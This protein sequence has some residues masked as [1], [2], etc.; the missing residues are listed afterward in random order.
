MSILKKWVGKEEKYIE[1]GKK[2]MNLW[3]QRIVNIPAMFLIVILPGLCGSMNH[4]NADT[5]WKPEYVSNQLII[6][7]KSDSPAAQTLFMSDENDDQTLVANSLDILKN[8]YKI[9]KNKTGFP[10][11]EK[12]R[13]SGT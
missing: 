9:K 1:S 10:G 5:D 6:K 12:E 3:F 11:A 2:S 8:K 13:D 4:A 7:F